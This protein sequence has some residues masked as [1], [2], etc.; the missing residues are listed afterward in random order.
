MLSLDAQH[1]AV[2]AAAREFVARAVLPIADRLDRASQEIPE[3]IIRSLAIVAEE[4]SRGW[5][6][7]G[8]VMTRNLIT[9]SL[10][11]A[12]GTDEQ[13]G[14]WLPGLA[15]GAILSTVA[16][17]EPNAGSDTASIQCAPASRAQAISCTAPRPGVPSPTARTCWRC[18]RTPIPTNP[19]AIIS[20][21]LEM[22][23]TSLVVCTYYGQVLC[24]SYRMWCQTRLFLHDC[25]CESVIHHY[26]G[27][28]AHDAPIIS[29]L[30]TILATTYNERHAT[31]NRP[32]GENNLII[33]GRAAVGRSRKIDLAQRIAI[34]ISSSDIHL[35][36]SHTC[37]G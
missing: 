15:R 12:N 24:E 7:V 18:W 26:L 36:F 4:P 37:M 20:S 13:K 25:L 9:S 32:H 33:Y 16:F 21:Q 10:L 28:R 17:T 19:G 14:R 34:Q 6:S 2:R 23:V 29:S 3:A 30:N 22:F 5:L 11:L 27:G 35:R 1:E 8:S 31:A